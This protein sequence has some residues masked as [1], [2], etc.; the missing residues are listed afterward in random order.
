MPLPNSGEKRVHFF[1]EMEI[2]SNDPYTRTR[3]Q[4]ETWEQKLPFKTM[5]ILY[6]E[7]KFDL[8]SKL[9]HAEKEYNFLDDAIKKGIK[10]RNGPAKMALL[11]S[12]KEYLKEEIFK[13]GTSLS[14]KR[15]DNYHLKLDEAVPD[16]YPVS[17]ILSDTLQS[18][19][20]AG[21]PEDNIVG[22]FTTKYGIVYKKKGVITGKE[23]SI[24][25]FFVVSYDDIFKNSNEPRFDILDTDEDGAAIKNEQFLNQS[26]F[27]QNNDTT[28]L[29]RVMN[30]GE[31]KSLGS[32]S[33]GYIDN[34][35]YHSIV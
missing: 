10:I 33:I 22:I 18:S 29:G 32:E 20:S 8:I 26:R 30:N 15:E 23:K 16:Q 2:T 34:K 9:K 27:Y 28:F 3:L 24:N 21:D 11:E 4:V 14:R 6:N 12:R 7:N 13:L 17:F 35:G 1:H 31:I 19:N 25:E 5:E